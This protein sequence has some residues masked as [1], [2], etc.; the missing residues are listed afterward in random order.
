M[1]TAV[2]D[3]DLDALPPT[4]DG[5]EG[6]DSA[7]ALL[8]VDGRPA[9]QAVLP[10]VDGRLPG[11]DLRTTL[12]A[13]ADSAFWEAWLRA[14][15]GER[16]APVA[17]ASLPRATVAV[18]TRDRTDDLRRCLAALEAMPDDG[19]ELVVVDNAPATESTRELVAEHPR[20]RYVREE[21]PGLDVARNRALREARHDVVAFTD[22][23]AAPDPRWLRTLLR[24]FD[25]PLVMAAAGATMALEL[26][27]D[28]Q[29]HFQRYGG[30]VRGFRRVVYDGGRHDPLLGWHAGAGV[31]MALRRSVVDAV[32][33]FDEALDAGTPTHAGGDS[34]MFRRILAAGWRIVYDPEAL[35][36]HRHR[37]TDAELLRQLH[38]YERAGFAILA[39]SLLYEGNLDAL[40]HAWQWLRRELPGLRRALREPAGSASRDTTL[41][42]LRGAVQG[43]RAYVQAH[44]RVRREAP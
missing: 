1:P 40:R 35:N 25:D 13:A 42:R 5:L 27:T 20:V 12:L 30:F 24:N 37:R 14:H 44:R 18:C 36:W 11:D 31:N 17:P 7:L 41:A 22:D 8:R 26:E 4:I 23:D 32:G 19:Q 15:L 9:G 3:L 29:V 28:A 38:G 34:D 16:P 33:P 21:R 39:R 10:V 6:C 43:P 2:L